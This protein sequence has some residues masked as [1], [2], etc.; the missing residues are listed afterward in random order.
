MVCL[1]LL[2]LVALLPSLTFTEDQAT[3]HLAR[4]IYALARDESYETKLA[5]AS[6][7]MNRV[8][9][10][11]YEGTLE[12]VLSSQHQFPSGERYDAQSLQAAHAAIA[13]KRNLPGDVLYYQAADAPNP[14]TEGLYRIIGGYAFYTEDG[15]F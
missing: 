10:P 9:N 2:F 13:G 5:I 6:V 15:N 11:W 1:A 4:T 8:E 12:E 3:V 7:V 14:W